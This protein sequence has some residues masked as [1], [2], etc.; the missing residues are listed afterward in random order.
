MTLWLE[1]GAANPTYSSQLPAP[2]R[3]RIF[4]NDNVDINDATNRISINIALRLGRKTA[5][6][7][8]WR[9]KDAMTA[10]Q[11]SSAAAMAGI[12]I[13]DHFVSALHSVEAILH[14]T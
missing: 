2:Q 11:T 1:R 6:A 14:T 5:A 10:D 3:Q 4:T 7:S 13:E 12:A 8:A 9:A